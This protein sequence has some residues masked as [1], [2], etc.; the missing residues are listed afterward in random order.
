[1]FKLFA[2]IALLAVL[3]SPAASAAKLNYVEVSDL[4]VISL[5]A[6][7]VMLDLDGDGIAESVGTAPI[8]AV[9]SY[10]KALQPG[11]VWCATLNQGADFCFPH[12]GTAGQRIAGGFRV[13]FPDNPEIGALGQVTPFVS[14]LFAPGPGAGYWANY[15]AAGLTGTYVWESLSGGGC[16]ETARLLGA[17]TFVGTQS[18]P[19]LA[20]T[21]ACSFPGNPTWTGLA[22]DLETG[23][24]CP[25]ATTITTNCPG[26][27]TTSGWNPPPGGGGGVVVTNDRIFRDGFE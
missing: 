26:G 14:N 18:V 21:P 22:V 20:G 16:R 1:M 12:G 11:K 24:F 25:N 6:N 7:E 3:A 19:A 27:G 2:T 8:W 17:T 13:S 10:S 5:D 15:R 4:G 23:N 9:P